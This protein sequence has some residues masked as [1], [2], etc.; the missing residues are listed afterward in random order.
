MPAKKPPTEAS[1]AEARD[2]REGDQYN[3][4]VDWIAVER[5]YRAGILSV[6][7]IAR[8]EGTSHT[9][10]N[11]KA[12]KERWTRN[13]APKVLAKA[14]EMAMMDI[15]QEHQEKKRQSKKPLDPTK[16][17]IEAIKPRSHE[18]KRS[19]AEKD[20]DAITNSASAIIT[21]LREHRADIR[22]G[23]DTVGKILADLASY[24][25]QSIRDL[26]EQATE[27]DADN[28]EATAKLKLALSKAINVNSRAIAVRDLMTALKTSIELERQALQI[29]ATGLIAEET[30]INEPQPIVPVL[31]FE[32]MFAK[33]RKADE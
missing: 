15:G 21:A 31:M 5:D 13:L 8:R 2:L 17:D 20:D 3:P 28:D 18:D 12:K 33:I 1:N 9:T 4:Q 23:R 11:R 10:I 14:K 26:L 25:E 32:E 19:Q 27:I 6:T 16:H 29:P 24:G 7:A 30:T 22:N